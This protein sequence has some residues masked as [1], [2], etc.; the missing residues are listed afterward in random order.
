[1]NDTLSYIEKDPIYRKHH[2][3]SL[4]FGLIYAFSENFI[5][6]V[7]HDEVVHGKRSLAGKM[8]GDH[9]QQLAN[10]RAYLGFMF[11]HPGKKLLFMGA[12]IAQWREWSEARSLDWDLLVDWEPNRKLQR[13]VAD[14]NHMYRSTPALY[15]VDDSV[16]GFEWVDFRDWENSVIAYL[17][18]AEDSSDHLL[19]ACNFT[20]VPREGYRV[21]VPEHCLYAEI[22]NSDAEI[23]WGS[24]MGNRGGFWSE[25]L[26]WQGQ[27]C[28][29]EITLPPLAVVVFQPQRG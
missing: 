13:Y 14:L 28:S 12:D 23:Y 29:L 24:N 22:L 6:V 11:T 18:K 10:L 16:E 27:P 4:T 5:L 15:Q 9:W 21:G 1:M 2:H 20:P 25:P 7:S 17:R 8:P 3:H 19:V 26:A